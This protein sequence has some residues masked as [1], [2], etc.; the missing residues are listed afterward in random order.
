MRSEI[1]DVVAAVRKSPANASLWPR[2][3]TGGGWSGGGATIGLPQSIGGDAGVKWRA[4]RADGHI[5]MF[6]IDYFDRGLSMHSPDPAD[7]AVTQR[8]A[9]C[10]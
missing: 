2:G 10:A 8:A 7:P 6:K 4:G 1:T 9:I 3:E 5:I